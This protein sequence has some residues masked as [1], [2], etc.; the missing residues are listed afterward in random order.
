MIVNDESEW[1]R[2][3]HIYIYIYI[4]ERRPLVGPSVPSVDPVD[5]LV[6]LMR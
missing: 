1:P 5:L 6:R 3:W 4:D 2:E